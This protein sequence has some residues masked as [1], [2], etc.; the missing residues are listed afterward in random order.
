M[1]EH[2]QHRVVHSLSLSLLSIHVFYYSEL[3]HLNTHTWYAAS[4]VCW[5]GCVCLHAV[6]HFIVNDSSI[7]VM[8]EQAQSHPLLYSFFLPACHPLQ[9][10]FPLSRTAEQT[11]N[12][13]CL[14]G[15]FHN[16]I[17]N[18]VSF[19]RPELFPPP[20]AAVHFP[21][22]NTGQAKHQGRCLAA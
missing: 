12:D 5:F 2:G 1:M 19:G 21:T 13:L 3:Q 7:A 8:L 16:Y 6:I 17:C 11:M 9:T 10:S 18:F 15:T 20:T 4:T 14:C 22:S